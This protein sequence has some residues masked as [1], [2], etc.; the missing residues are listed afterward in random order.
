MRHFLGLDIGVQGIGLAVVPQNA[1]DFEK[2]ALGVH[3]FE[4]G[5]DGDV[6][7]GKDESRNLVRRSARALRRAYRRRSQRMIRLS[8]ELKRLGLLPSCRMHVPEERNAMLETLD[9]S[10]SGIFLVGDRRQAH[11]LPYILRTRGLDQ[12]LQEELTEYQETKDLEELADLLE[13]I[14]A[15][16]KARGCSWEQLMQIRDQKRKQRGGFEKKILLSEVIVE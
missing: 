10:L 8:N 3:L 14:A 9:Q 13:V 16:A 11:L 4:G 7:K 12:K 2:L 5:T 1:A 6:E 15:A